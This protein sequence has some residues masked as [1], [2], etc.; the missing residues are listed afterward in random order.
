MPGR[1][2]L[3]GAILLQAFENVKQKLFGRLHDIARAQIFPA[4]MLEAEKLAAA[5]RKAHAVPIVVKD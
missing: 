4:G 3:C 1:P 2:T 5:E